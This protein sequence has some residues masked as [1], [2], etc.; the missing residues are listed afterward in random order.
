MPDEK[1]T[2]KGNCGKVLG[3][4][5]GI[6]LFGVIVGFL[7]NR[8][9]KAWAGFFYPDATNTESTSIIEN[10]LKSLEKCRKWAQAEAKDLGLA[11]GVWDYECGTGCSISD[12]TTTQ[13]RAQ[14]FN[15]YSCSEY[16]K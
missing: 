13:D 10:N 1:Q 2:F 11:E 8:E 14:G 4:C 12:S 9:Q 5:L 3:G 16:T 7:M 15:R 6:I